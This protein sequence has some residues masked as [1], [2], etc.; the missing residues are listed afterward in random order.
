MCFLS[1]CPKI[2]AMLSILSSMLDICMRV[3]VFIM[4]YFIR[5]LILR[6]SIFSTIRKPYY[7][8]SVDFIMA[9][10]ADALRS[11]KISGVH[12]KRC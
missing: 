7:R 2:L 5:N 3:P 1:M 8:K 10:F 9:G 6:L 4:I 12:F 11:E